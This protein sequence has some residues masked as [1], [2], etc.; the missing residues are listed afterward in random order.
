MSESVTIKPAVNHFYK[1]DKVSKSSSK[2]HVGTHTWTVWTCVGFYLIRC[3]KYFA[4]NAHSQFAIWFDSNLISQTEAKSHA[5]FWIDMLFFSFLTFVTPCQICHASLFDT[6]ICR[7]MYACAHTYISTT[8]R[9]CEFV[10]VGVSHGVCP[11]Q[12]VRPSVFSR[13]HRCGS[14]VL[15]RAAYENSPVLITWSTRLLIRHTLL[16]WHLLITPSFF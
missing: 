5:T 11:S 2:S 9:V 8:F 14:L 13:R 3:D 7:C 6:A 4:V 1:T 15:P 12:L 10:C 16:K